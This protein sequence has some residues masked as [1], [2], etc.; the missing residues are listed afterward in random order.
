MKF[1]EKPCNRQAEPSTLL[2]V[3]ATIKLEVGANLGNILRFDATTVIADRDLI[4]V[5]CLLARDRNQA[6]RG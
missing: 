4:V 3:K 2:L 1:S 6:C 5:R